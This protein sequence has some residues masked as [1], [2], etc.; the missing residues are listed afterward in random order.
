MISNFRT[1]GNLLL[2]GV[3]ERHPKLHVVSVES[4]LGWIPFLLEG[5]DYEIARVRAAHRRAPL[6]EAVGVLPAPG[7]RLL[8]VRA[9]QLPGRARSARARQHHVRDRLPAPDVPVPRPL[10]GGGAGARRRRARSATQAPQ[11]ERGRRS[12]GSRCPLSFPRARRRQIVSVPKSSSMLPAHD[13]AQ[14]GS[15]RRQAGVPSRSGSAPQSPSPWG[16]SV[17]N[18][19]AVDADDVGQNRRAWLSSAVFGGGEGELSRARV[20]TA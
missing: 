4:G 16:Q 7:A 8:L 18:R 5:L 11:H 1:M 20:A 2:S 14:L 6:D 12:T 3:L 13:L 10:L 9:R 19:T 17:T 15:R